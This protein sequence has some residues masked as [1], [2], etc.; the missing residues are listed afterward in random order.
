ML[1]HFH[2]TVTV[3]SYYVTAARISSNQEGNAIQNSIKVPLCIDIPVAIMSHD[4]QS[5]IS[6]KWQG[7]APQQVVCKGE[8]ME[9]PWQ[10]P[11][12]FYTPHDVL[13]PSYIY[14]G[15]PC[16]SKTYIE[17]VTCLHTAAQIVKFME[18]TWAH[19]GPCYQG[20]FIKW[21]LLTVPHNY[22][23][24]FM[25]LFI[26]NGQHNCHNILHFQGSV[27]YVPKQA[28]IENLTL[29]DNILFGKRNAKKKY[30][31]VLRDCCLVDDLK[32]LPGND[33][34]EIGEK[35][36]FNEVPVRCHGATICVKKKKHH[37]H[38]HH[39]SLVKVIHKDLKQFLN[40]TVKKICFH[41]D[42]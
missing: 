28:W 1:G 41:V 32:T 12:P 4:H 30:E 18:S 13:R 37:H 38:Q 39:P 23:K 42:L 27:A 26:C 35:V 3:A 11:P 36:W 19:L 8:I 7:F 40:E 16:T 17:K 20:V 33:L 9:R 15:N 34:T 29:R 2:W 25:F 31:S 21:Y 22:M 24:T 10:Q 6:G 5:N 14:N